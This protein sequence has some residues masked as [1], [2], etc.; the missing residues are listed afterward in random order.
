[1]AYFQEFR[2]AREPFIKA[3][4]AVLVLIGILVAAHVAR[5]LAPA[6]I[7]DGLVNSYGL[8]AAI[9]SPKALH[10]L[11]AAPPGLYALVAPLIGHMFL[12]ANATHLIF[13]C[14]WLLV[15]GSVVARRFGPLGFYLFF[16]LCGLGGAAAFVALDW[17][18]LVGAIGASGAI[19]GLMG[20]A[21][22]MMN[23]RQPWLYGVAQPLQSLLSNQV[24]WFSAVWLVVNLVTGLAGFA[25]GAGIEAIAWQDHLGGYLVGLVL[26]GP[27][28][29]LFGP[30]FARRAA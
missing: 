29:R 14:L 7:S 24:V 5:V 19:S 23:L 27:F 3:P 28:D 22:R 2:P 15:F 4:A 21:V 11:G 25:P 10:A 1:M 8:V 13:N 9:Y 6:D 30:D 18:Q 20:A 17:G 16:L 12:H 26:A